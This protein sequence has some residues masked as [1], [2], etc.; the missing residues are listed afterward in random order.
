MGRWARSGLLLTSPIILTS[1]ASPPSSPQIPAHPP[2]PFYVESGLG[3][4]H[5]NYISVQ[6]DGETKGPGGVRCFT[7]IWDRPLTPQ[8]ALRLRSES[9][10]DPKYPGLFLANEL[11]R[12]V[13]PIASSTLAQD[14][15]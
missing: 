11:E 4:E 6:E 14:G 10:E 15:N 2:K 8:T 1:C 12:T 7:Y 5:G 9:C 13:I 3:S